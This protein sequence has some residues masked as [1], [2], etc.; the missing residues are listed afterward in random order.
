MLLVFFTAC[1]K[2]A[3][4]GGKNTIN[5]SVVYKNGVSGNTDPASNATV[6][7][8]YGTSESTSEFDQIILA[9]GSGKF[10]VRGLR[11]GNYFIKAGYTDAHGFTYNTSGSVIELKNKK[12][13]LE[14]NM[15]LE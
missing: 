6:S 7:I 12:N 1:K 4:P 13:S 8:A 9:D 11:K 15:V 5:G 10:S 3:A 14:V 2:E